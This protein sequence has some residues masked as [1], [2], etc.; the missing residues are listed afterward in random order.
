MY[1]FSFISVWWRWIFSSRWLIPTCSNCSFCYSYSWC[2][3]RSSR[4]DKKKSSIWFNT[5]DYFLYLFLISHAVWTGRSCYLLIYTLKYTNRC[6]V[7]VRRTRNDEE[8]ERHSQSSRQSEKK[9]GKVYTRESDEWTD[10]IR[11][12]RC[13]AIWF[14]FLFFIFFI[15]IVRKRDEKV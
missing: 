7:Y 6:T 9:R 3:V 8:T 5:N 2:N 12:G 10:D 1:V 11:L 4:G 13:R 15:L 14:L